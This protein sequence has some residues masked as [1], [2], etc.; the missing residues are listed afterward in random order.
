MMLSTS[1]ILA[2]LMAATAVQAIPTAPNVVIRQSS[3]SA[4]GY[5]D[6]TTNGGSMLSRISTASNVGEPLNVIISGDS[7]KEVLT[8]EG[9]SEYFES[10][11]FSPGSCAGISAG[12]PQ[13]ADLGDGKGF[14]NQTDV[15]RFNYYEGDGGTCLE[16]I[17]G[18]NHL[19]YWMQNGTSANTGA[20]FVAASVEYPA[21]QSHNIVPGGYDLGRDWIS[22]NATNS[23]GTTSPGGYQYT[24]T[25]TQ[26]A[27]LQNIDS[28]LLNHGIGVD[29]NVDVLTV[30]VT[31][32]GKQGANRTNQG[33]ANSGI[34]GSLASLPKLP[35]ATVLSAVLLSVGMLSIAV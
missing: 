18:G 32:T 21:T 20:I 31:K 2:A 4:S 11:F 24:T 15:L 17:R 6:P 27:L 25:R 1:G 34:S 22:G 10:L 30:K 5:A 23:S 16:S 9:A 8:S 29:G 19:R 28:S 12:G 13:L 33:D 3:S 35:T 26:V 14:V 7:D